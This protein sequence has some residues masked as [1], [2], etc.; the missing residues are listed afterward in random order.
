MPLRRDPTSPW[1]AVTTVLIGGVPWCARTIRGEP[2]DFMALRRHKSLDELVGLLLVD[3]V[4]V[5][6]EQ[7]AAAS[8]SIWLDGAVKGRGILAFPVGRLWTCRMLQPK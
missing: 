7:R 5:R 1:S 8:A 6:R 4:F 2:A 3:P